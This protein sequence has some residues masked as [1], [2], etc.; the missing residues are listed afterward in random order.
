MYVMASPLLSSDVNRKTRIRPPA[1]WSFTIAGSPPVS[2]SVFNG[3]HCKAGHCPV[4]T[5]DFYYDKV[6]LDDYE[7]LLL[8]FPICLGLM[9]HRTIKGMSNQHSLGVT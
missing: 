5:K 9:S 2:A 7:E 4:L 8:S 3:S 1:S 6:G